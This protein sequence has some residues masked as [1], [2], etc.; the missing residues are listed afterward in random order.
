MFA[1]DLTG[2]TV[3]FLTFLVNF[4]HSFQK[5]SGFRYDEMLFFDDEYRNIV[6]ITKLGW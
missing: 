4:P 5:N 2:N 3:R 1:M 6:D